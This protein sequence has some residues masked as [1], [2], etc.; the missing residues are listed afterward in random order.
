[1][2]ISNAEVRIKGR[3]YSLQLSKQRQVV[4]G[5]EYLYVVDHE[6]CQIRFG[7]AVRQVIRRAI[8][9]ARATAPAE[10]RPL[11]PWVRVSGCYQVR[12]RLWPWEV[13]QQ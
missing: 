8:S 4:N 10:D 6:A 5:R 3:P 1:M 12:R 13:A 11:G 2:S 7:V 9:F